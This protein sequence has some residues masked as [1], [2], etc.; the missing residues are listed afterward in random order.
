MLIYFIHHTAESI[1]ADHVITEVSDELHKAIIRLF[2]EELGQDKPEHKNIKADIPTD[3]NDSA[4]P[5]SVQKQGYLQT[6]DDQQLIKIAKNHNLV[7]RLNYRPGDFLMRGDPL[8]E[9][10]PKDAINKDLAKKLEKTFII[11]SLRTQQQDIKFVVDQLVEIASRALSPGLNDPFTAIRC[12][13]RLGAALSHLAQ[14]KIPSSYRYDDQ[15]HL[16]IIAHPV[17]FAEVTDTAFNQIRQ[18]GCSHPSVVIRLLKT[19]SNIAFYTQDSQAKAALRRHADSIKS[20]SLESILEEGDR[21]DIEEKYQAV[22]SALK[23]QTIFRS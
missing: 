19:L 18:Y 9:V 16:R 4:Y 12:I 8:I 23:N 11:D 10:W 1:Q 2:P 17:T 7:V 20:S 22:L 14:R 6:I 13:D 3:F 21:R 15:N 5:I